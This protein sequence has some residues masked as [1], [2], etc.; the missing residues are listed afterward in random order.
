M[1]TACAF[2]MMKVSITMRTATLTISP[3]RMPLIRVCIGPRV[4]ACSAGS[5]GAEGA[6]GYRSCLVVLAVRSWR[7][8]LASGG[9]PLRR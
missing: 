3:V 2:W 4:G 7:C 5:G 6:A 8:F 1:F 9:G